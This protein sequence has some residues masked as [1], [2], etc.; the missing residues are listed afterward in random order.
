MEMIAVK[1]SCVIFIADWLFR[2]TFYIAPLDDWFKIN[3]TKL[4]SKK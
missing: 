4:N 3:D 1:K 2:K